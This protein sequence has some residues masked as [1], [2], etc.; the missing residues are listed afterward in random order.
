MV[1]IEEAAPMLKLGLVVDTRT[2]SKV[3]VGIE[4]AALMLKLGLV[5]DIRTPSKVVV[6]IEEAAPS[7]KLV[8]AGARIRR[9]A[10]LRPFCLLKATLTLISYIMAT[11]DQRVF[12]S[13]VSVFSFGKKLKHG[14]VGCH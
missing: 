8:W 13:K 11:D 7:A 10:V 5:V 3:V 2:P 14:L 4:E 6:G 12:L 9:T 1:G